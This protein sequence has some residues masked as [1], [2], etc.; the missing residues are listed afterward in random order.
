MAHDPRLLKNQDLIADL[1]KTLPDWITRLQRPV[2]PA[3]VPGFGPL[4]GI[5]VVGT[6]TFVAQPYIGT[7]LAEFG[8]EVIHMERPAYGAA[9]IWSGRAATR[10]AGPRPS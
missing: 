1:R 3:V 8:A 5:R 6:G 2:T 10:S 7:K 9:G 4:E